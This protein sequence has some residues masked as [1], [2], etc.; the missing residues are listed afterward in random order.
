MSGVLTSSLT[1]AEYTNADSWESRDMGGQH[2]VH[3]RQTDPAWAPRERLPSG[4]RQVE[5]LIGRNVAPD[6]A[7]PLDRV[8]P[9]SFLL[10]DHRR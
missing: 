7:G 3:S 4:R 6:G 2:W 8:A 10:S 9:C 1:H 5:I